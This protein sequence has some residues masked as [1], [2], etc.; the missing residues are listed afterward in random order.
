MGLPIF[1]TKRGTTDPKAIEVSPRGSIYTNRDLPDFAHLVAEG[2]VWRANESSATASVVA[3]PTTAGLFT[4]GNNEPDDGNWYI[5]IAAY[6]FNAA[7]AAALDAFALAGVISQRRALTGGLDVT[8]A[9][10]IASGTGVVNQLGGQ[11]VYNG[12][13]I[14][15]AGVAVTDDRW[16]PLGQGSGSTAINSATGMSIWNWLHGLVILPPKTLFS[17]VSTATSTSNT[18]TKGVVWAEVPKKYLLG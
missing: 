9:R 11:I 3:L 8:M 5:V 17:M 18:T 10:D 1:G 15:D 2:R 7:N 12:N 4:L 14:L 16:F 13:A 6:A